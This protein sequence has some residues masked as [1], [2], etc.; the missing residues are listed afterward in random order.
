MTSKKVKAEKYHMVN[1]I[2]IVS[3]DNHTQKDFDKFL[4]H[5]V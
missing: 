2:Q 1:K 3:K 5:F 4:H